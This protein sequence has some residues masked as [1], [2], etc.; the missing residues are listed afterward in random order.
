MS[1]SRKSSPAWA[2][3]SNGS[4]EWRGGAAYFRP[5]IP[6][7]LALIPGSLLGEA[8]PGHRL[9]A[10]CLILAACL[11][12]GFQRLRSQGAVFWPLIL[13]FSL[14]YL[15]VQPW[16]APRFPANH[17]VHFAASHP[18]Q[19][20]GQVADLPWVRKDRVRFVLAATQLA[21]K[22]QRFSVRGR[23]RVTVRP[24]ELSLPLRPGALVRFKGRIRRPRNYQNP[25]GFDYQRYMAT[26]RLWATSYAWKHSF[27]LLEKGEERLFSRPVERYRRSFAR[28]LDQAAAAPCRAILKALIIGDKSELSPKLRE[29]FSQAGIAHLLAISGLHIGI[30]ASLAFLG[31]T[32]LLSHYP[33]L[34]WSGRTRKGAALLTLFPV[35][36]YGLVAGMSPATQ[37]AVTVAGLFFLGLLLDREPEPFNTLAG[38]ALLI[39]MVHPPALFTVSF[40]LSFVAVLAILYGLHCFPPPQPPDSGE[41]TRPRAV[42]AWLRRWGLGF[43]KVTLFAVLGTLPLILY[44]FNTLSLAGLA[45]NF[46]FVPLI[47]YLAVPLGLVAVFIY[48]IS[49]TVAAW[50]VHAA[51][52]VLAGSLSLL[53]HFA[54]L[55]LAGVRTVRPSVLEILC[56]YLLGWSLLALWGR[57]RTE[58]NQRLAKAVLLGLIPVLLADLGYW[59]WQRFGRNDLAVTAIDVGQGSASLCRLPGGDCLL[60][61][62]GGFY[63][64]SI[65][66]VGK[67]LVAPFLWRQKIA[68]V[69]TLAL[70]HPDGDHLNGLLFIA[71]HFH[72]QT[73]WTNGARAES[74]NLA[75]FLEIL[76]KSGASLPCFSRL[77]RERTVNGVK[78][79]ICYPPPDY[80]KNGQTGPFESDNNRSL[81]IRLRLGKIS[82]LFPGDIEAPAER[83]LVKQA[84]ETLRSTVLMAPHHGSKSSS[85][86]AFIDAV[87]PRVVVISAGW[88]NRF[89]CPHAAVLR[90]YEKR[91]IQVFRTDMNGAVRMR[92]DGQELVIAPMRGEKLKLNMLGSGP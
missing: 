46:V 28:F 29:R 54:A 15:S 65:F 77:D 24:E 57:A 61:D 33:P 35:L 73:A 79:E 8:F 37:R 19:I 27:A 78:I 22:N 72:V 71:R 75:T 11:A 3:Q 55:P 44:Y 48:P 45:S 64:N 39:L 89:G 50:G 5:L 82:F 81:V 34:L 88:R 1:G 13:F 36:A 68:T 60:I 86:P 7:L 9:S 53:D 21:Q 80:L 85:S 74:G 59:S 16:L 84:G 56:Y 31:V 43:F 30:V 18:W 70:S 2:R 49:Q 52:A 62:G 10:V 69:E 20:T 58:E 4:P 42:A 26:R 23:I 40:Q 67:N 63:D 83:H 17:V 90:R 76:N 12:I 32:R 47:G 87:S 91:G 25:G 66:D 6:L 51:E 38:A 92:T 14:G 41:Q